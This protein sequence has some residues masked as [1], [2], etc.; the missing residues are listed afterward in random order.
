M[1]SLYTIA[2][3]LF[4]LTGCASNAVYFGTATNLGIDISSESTNIIGYKNTQIARVPPTQKG[5]A[6]S[7]LGTSDVDLSLTDVAIYERFATGE[8]ADCAAS[9][10]A[11]AAALTPPTGLG[12]LIFGSYTSISFIDFNFGATNPFVGGSMGYKRATATMIPITNDKL[13]SVYAESSVNTIKTAD[14]ADPAVASR[15]GGM[16][17]VQNFATG[18]AAMIRAKA[19]VKKLTGDNSA[20]STCTP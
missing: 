4:I 17:F 19:N 10:N 1:R 7:V 16:R 3:S 6:F 15:T 5:D 8:A 14:G 2:F 11:R 12:S 13:R 20:V 9:A 18:K